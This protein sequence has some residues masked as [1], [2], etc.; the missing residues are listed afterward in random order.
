MG[1]TEGQEGICFFGV[2]M[3]ATA[4]NQHLELTFLKTTDAIT[5]AVDLQASSEVVLTS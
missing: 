5:L 1:D 4:A 2:W 3:S